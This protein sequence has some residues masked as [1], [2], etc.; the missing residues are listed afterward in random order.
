MSLTHQALASSYQSLS[1]Q[2]LASPSFGN[3]GVT[4]LAKGQMDWDRLGPTFT[5]ALTSTC[6]LYTSPSPRDS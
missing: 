1:S 5:K 2:V 6:L 3:E 4:F